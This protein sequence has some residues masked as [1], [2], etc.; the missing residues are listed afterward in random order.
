MTERAGQERVSQRNRSR[1]RDDRD[2]QA[3]GDHRGMDQRA[4]CWKRR[5]AGDPHQDQRSGEHE[6]VCRAVQQAEWELL[7]D[8]CYQQATG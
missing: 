4:G 6:A 2:E 8:Y 1:T 5:A 7:F 3:D